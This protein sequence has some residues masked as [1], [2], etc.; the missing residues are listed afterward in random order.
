MKNYNHKLNAFNRALESLDVM[1][2][3][4]SLINNAEIGVPLDITRLYVW[5]WVDQPADRKN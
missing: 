2:L 3:I 4:R 5:L 1:T